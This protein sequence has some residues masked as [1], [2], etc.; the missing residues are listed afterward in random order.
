[1]PGGA[2]EHR[3]SEAMD[4]LRSAGY[5]NLACETTDSSVVVWCENRRIRYPVVWMIEA[6]SVAASAAPDDVM[7]HVVA[8]RLAIPVTGL[9]A[10]AGDIRA[11]LNGSVGTEEFRRSIRVEFAG[12]ERPPER[13][14][15]S[16]RKV[17][18]AIGPGRILSEFG[19]PGVWIRANFDVSAEIS[20]AFLPGLNASGRMF[21][22]AYN[23][24]GPVDNDSRYNELRPGSMLL[25]YLRPVGRSGFLSFCGGMVE[26]A[27]WRYDSY[28]VVVDAKQYSSDGSWG[29]GGSL[30]YVAPGRYQVLNDRTQR[31]RSWIFVWPLHNTPYEAWASYRVTGF[32][33]RMTA[34]WGR[35][36]VGDRAWR[37]DVERSFGE[38]K[39]TVFGIKS[40]GY[41]DYLKRVDRQNTR[42]LGGVRM[43]IPL[44]P[45]ERGMPDRFRVTSAPA[46]AWSYRYRV[47]DV[48][49]DLVTRQAVED[50]V[51]AYN[52]ITIYNN[53]ERARSQVR[54]RQPEARQ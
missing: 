31:Y 20:T 3:C 34:R 38:T 36:L 27:N 35:Y 28:G 48:G 17:D 52:P 40:D 50:H 7:V 15:S 47:G 37:M 23:T 32:D 43:E 51:G 26:M 9:S 25:S 11:W 45:R 13:H 4:R 30:G 49:V 46:F 5:E 10:R 19:L 14:S 2:S 21:F 16:L 8:E 6:L 24:G 39:I 42:L 53:L 18:L 54:A 22:P 44:P 1:M 12:S 33:L 29:V 41:S